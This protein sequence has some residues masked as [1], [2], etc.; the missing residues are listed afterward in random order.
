[1]LENPDVESI[2]IGYD[3]GVIVNRRHLVK[4]GHIKDEESI[5]ELVEEK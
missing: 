1:M 4:A 5:L 2:D 3:N